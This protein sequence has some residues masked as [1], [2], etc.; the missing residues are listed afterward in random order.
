MYSPDSSISGSTITT[1]TT[2]AF[3]L[4]GVLAPAWNAVKKIVTAVSGT[5]TSGVTANSASSPFEAVFYVPQVLR[6]T[7]KPNPITGKYPPIPV[8]QYRLVVKKGGKVNADG[9]QATAV[10]KL[11]FDIPAGMETADADQV[12]ALVSFII[13][14]ATEE[15]QDLVDTLI[16]GTA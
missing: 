8:N 7:P 14:L 9:T 11:S 13:G 12:K 4:A 2:P 16:A 3:T 10:A 5:G 15:S 1:F 6:S